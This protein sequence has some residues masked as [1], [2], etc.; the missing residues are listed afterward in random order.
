[1]SSV[2][3]ILTNN[4]IGQQSEIIHTYCYGNVI[5]IG[6]VTLPYNYISEDYRGSYTIYIPFYDKTCELS[7]PC[8][9][10]IT[11][12]FGNRLISENGA[13]IIVE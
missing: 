10:V 6:T 4:Y 11:D 12:E 2:L 7:V 3:Q 1:M 5:D 13:Y 9:P 8:I